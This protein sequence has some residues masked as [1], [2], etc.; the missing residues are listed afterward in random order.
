VWC[1]VGGGALMDLYSQKFTGLGKAKG[2]RG[3]RN[4][5]WRVATAA[6]QL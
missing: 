5:H 6:K 4:L 1:T 2:S 3:R